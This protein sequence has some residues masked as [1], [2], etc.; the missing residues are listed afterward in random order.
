M[1]AFVLDASVTAAWLLPDEASEHTRRLYALIRRDEVDPQAPN[2]WQWECA[3]II[4]NGVRRGRIPTSSVEG[5]W[6]VLEAVRHRVE[7][8]ELAPAQH[9]ASLAVAL[10]AGLSAY[11]AGY[12]WLARSLNLP[13]LTFDRRL[14]E[15][16][17]AC[18][19]RL[20]DIAS[21]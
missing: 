21:L 19:V 10:D 9:K 12:M 1:T 13:L 3:N 4:A 5:L 18:G 17:P 6:S 15:A 16:A 8:H 2:L 11:D 20:L 14:S 7:L